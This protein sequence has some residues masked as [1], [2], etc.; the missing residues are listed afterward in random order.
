MTSDVVLTAALR[1]NLLSL[2]N[3]QSLIDTTQFR[4]ATGRKINSALDGPQEF[5]ASQ[6]LNNRASDLSRLLDAMGQSIQVI[7]AA[8][9]GIT[10]LTTLVEQA[11]SIANSARDTLA[12]GQAEAKVTGDRDLRGV[13]NLFDLPGIGQAG[14]GNTDSLVFSITDEDGNAVGLGAYGA[15]TAATATVSID[16]LTSI[17]DLIAAINDLTLDDGNGN[18]TGDQ[19][20]EAS[21]DASGQLQIRTLNGGD[22]NLNFVAFND[23]DSENL[24]LANELGFGSV[25]R[26]M[27][28]GGVAPSNNVEFTSVADV[29]LDS[30]TFYNGAIPPQIAQASEQ[31]A[32]LTD[33]AGVPYFAGIDNVVDDYQI[34]INGGPVQTIDL[35]DAGGASVSIQNFVDQINSNGA[36]NEHIQAAY[37]ATTGVLSIE[38]IGAEVV[39]IEV[40]FTGDTAADEANFGFGQADFTLA[41]P[42]E[43]IRES[44]RLA[45]AAAE[46]AQFETDFNR[47]RDQISELVTNG[48]TGYRGTNL[49][50]GDNLFTVFNEFRTSTL[51]TNGV[52]FTAD[53][54]GLAE[55]NFSRISSTEG[56]LASV[57]TALESVRNFGLTLA[58]D[59]SVIQTRESFTKS[60]I[61]TLTEGAD[62]LTVADQNE[63]GAKMLALQT[64]QQ[65]GVTSLSLASQSQQSILRLF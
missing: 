46:L 24:S 3:T 25:A 27:P 39:S 6:A 40:G 30:F 53:G 23:T 52:T 61:N 49:L 51:T 58:A 20:F 18:A 36:L 14:A 57:R 43:T 41:N 26:V 10:A 11:D 44:I 47:V 17:N 16:D 7:K 22:F 9:H 12:A 19:A 35:T 42:G 15:A 1:N 45:A 8:D 55:A 13:D 63:E 59:L 37:D 5:F 29:V 65:L 4:L 60:M 48:D 38:P 64:R 28:D 54:L 62:K 56:T 21:L 34:S 32:N 2:Q 33:D 31:L 50:N